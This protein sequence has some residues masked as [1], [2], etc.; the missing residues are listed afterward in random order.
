MN[1]KKFLL[2]IVL[3]LFTAIGCSDR[4]RD[5]LASIGIDG[6][7]Y[8]VKSGGVGF[9][10]VKNEVD[11][12]SGQQFMVEMT[13]SNNTN[14]NLIFDST[15]F[16]LIAKSGPEISLPTGNDVIGIANQ[17]FYNTSISPGATE[18]C[19]LMFSVKE[20]GEYKLKITSPK[21][22]THEIITL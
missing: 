2:A 12:S 8:N 22:K 20:A 15:S 21:S 5:S 17:A 6:V 3:L 9:E 10:V 16:L 11:Y 19:I 18:I 4:K 1:E 14:E 13:V 7:N